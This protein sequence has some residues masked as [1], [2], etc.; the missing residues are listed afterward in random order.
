[1]PLRM[2][3]ASI[4]PHFERTI[5]LAE[6]TTAPCPSQSWA[7]ASLPHRRRGLGCRPIRQNAKHPAASASCHSL[8]WMLSH[9]PPGPAH[10]W[11]A[12][13][14]RT[15]CNR[16][17]ETQSN[18][19]L[20]QLISCLLSL[21]SF[22]VAARPQAPQQ[23]A[24]HAPEGRSCNHPCTAAQEQ[25]KLTAT[26]PLHALSCSPAPERITPEGGSRNH[27]YTAW[28]VVPTTAMSKLASVRIA[29]SVANMCT[30]DTPSHAA[31]CP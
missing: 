15:T 16:H 5:V 2:L 29:G 27:P 3:I 4:G 30:P 12:K 26:Q 11:F 9:C 8:S 20:G 28:R 10:I 23:G 25:L 21:L 22:L 24:P 17:P 13:T 7:G 14:T 6:T 19:H 1:M 18:T 31:L